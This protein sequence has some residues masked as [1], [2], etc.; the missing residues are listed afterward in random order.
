MPVASA[1]SPHTPRP[2]QQSRSLLARRRVAP[3][4]LLHQRERLYRCARH[5]LLL[6][7]QVR[8]EPPLLGLEEAAVAAAAVAA[9]VAASTTPTSVTP[10]SPF[11]PLAPALTASSS[12]ASFA[13]TALP[14]SLTAA[15]L[16]ATLATAAVATALRKRPARRPWARA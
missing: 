10:R 12:A 5:R 15:A 7:G 16:T 6:E 2:M 13:S 4:E 8:A 11:A 14:S 3:H 1:A 9:A